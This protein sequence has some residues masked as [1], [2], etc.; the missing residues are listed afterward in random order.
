MSNNMSNRVDK[1]YD[2]N[3]PGIRSLTEVCDIYLNIYSKLK[4]DI[5][6]TNS[7][8]LGW[9]TTWMNDASL[10]QFLGSTDPSL[11]AVFTNNRNMF[12]SLQ[13]ILTT[14][15]NLTKSIKTIRLPNGDCTVFTPNTPLGTG[16]ILNQMRSIKAR[17]NLGQ[18]SNIGVDVSAG[19]VI[20]FK[21]LTVS[22][23][24]TATS[25][26]ISKYYY[27]IG[28]FPLEKIEVDTWFGS[29]S[30]GTLSQFFKNVIGF[31]GED[32]AV[33]PTT[34]I[35]ERNNRLV[36]QLAFSINMITDLKKMLTYFA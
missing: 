11:N 9:Y 10:N 14:Q 6:I 30:A 26:Y 33:G 1:L 32:G 13:L 4:N 12:T 22:S 7:S 20:D 34:S 31:V 19:G 18:A 21:D 8:L 28:T 16:T 15:Y 3:E 24:D 17:Y 36:E 29:S 5:I 25:R 35:I 23:F 2:S 27:Q